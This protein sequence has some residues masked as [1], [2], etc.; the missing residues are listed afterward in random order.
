MTANRSRTV[1]DREVEVQDSRREHAIRRLFGLQ[2]SGQGRMG[3]DAVD[4]SGNEYEL[5]STTKEGVSTARDV[6]PHTIE[7]W[8]KRYWLFA[9]GR[10]LGS[11]FEIE[12][13]YFLHPDDMEGWFQ[14]LEKRFAQDLSLLRR[15]KPVLRQAGLSPQEIERLQYLVGRGLTLNNPKVP[16]DYVRR[17]G[18]LIKGDHVTTR[19]KLVQKRPL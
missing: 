12:A 3:A 13:T 18:V 8:R 10:N 7:K 15:A 11:G 6:G 17:H 9:K 4:D 14:K 19:R 2:K 16:W 5:K 1:Q